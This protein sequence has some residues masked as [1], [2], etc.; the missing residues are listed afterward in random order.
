MKTVK[1]FGRWAVTEV[2]IEHLGL[3]S[4]EIDK[5]V[6]FA[7]DWLA[8]MAEKRWVKMD[9]FARAHNFAISY[10]ENKKIAA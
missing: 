4:Y 3:P 6:L 5:A 2:G 8:H 1:K 7:A 9:D 10:Y